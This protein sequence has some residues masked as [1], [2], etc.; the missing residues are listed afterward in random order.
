MSNSLNTSTQSISRTSKKKK[1]LIPIVVLVIGFG[2]L[3]FSGAM[4]PKPQKK[5]VAPK[6]PL[7]EVIEVA[8]QNVRFEIA[9]QGS[10]SPRTET[11][12]VSEVSGVVKSVS[13][14]FVVG[15]F[16]KKGELLLE[17]DPISYEV[18]LLQAQARL[19]GANA[20]LV[21]EKAKGKQAEKEWSLT[22]RAKNNAPILALRKP[23]LQQAKADVKAA[24]ADVRNAQIRLDRTRIIAPYDAMLKAKIV[25]IG[26]YVST[27]SQLATTFAIDY[28]EIRLPIK[29]Q[30]F[31]YIEVPELGSIGEQGSR[32]LLTTI[33]AGKLKQWETFISRSEGFVDEKSRVHYVVAQIHDP[34]GV[35]SL[36]AN[37]VVRMG[38]FVKAIVFGREVAN[39]IPV[40]RKAVRGAN[41]VYLFNDDK[42][43]NY[44]QIDILTADTDNVYIAAGLNDGDKVILTKLETAIDGMKLRLEGDIDSEDDEE[45]LKADSEAEVSSHSQQKQDAEQGESI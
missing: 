22:G 16:F 37:P 39:V 40:P 28:A 19:D 1:I 44:A 12:L 23:Q 41:E 36:Q 20:K 2:V 9:S 26:Q 18:A 4:A 38:T 43:L 5:T 27:G 21:E 33:Q 35:N 31:E 8:Q 15:G 29:E 32:V 13:E 30:D 11:T 25:D 34:Y 6:A 24:E 42:K 10:V 45:N 17:I 3:A 14:K 7:V